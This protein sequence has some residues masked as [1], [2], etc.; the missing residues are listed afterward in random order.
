MASELITAFNAGEA[1]RNLESRKD[2]DFYKRLCSVAENVDILSEGGATTRAGT[3]YIATTKNNTVAYLRPF[4]YS[5]EYSYVMELG[6]TYARIYDNQTEAVVANLVTPWGINDVQ[7]LDFYRSYDVM[8][9]CHPDHPTQ[10]ITRT[11]VDAFSIAEIE[12]DYPPLLEPNVTAT[13]LTVGATTGTG[14]ALTASADLFD[15]SH[16]GAVFAI[17]HERTAAQ[18]SV[19]GSSSATFQSSALDVS[20][21]NW[22]ID[23]GGT[24][25]GLLM[26]ERSFDGGSTWEAGEKIAD[27]TNIANANFF[28]ESTTREGA[29]TLIRIN[30]TKS[31]TKTP[32]DY[33]LSVIDLYTYGLVE[34]TAVTDAQNAVCTVL[35]TVGATSATTRWS[36]GAFS[37]YRGYPRTVTR[38]EDRLIFS[39]TNSE[40]NMLWMSYTG[41]YY[42][43]FA[44]TLADE[45]IRR[46]PPANGFTQWMVS[47]GDLFIGTSS[48]LITVTGYNPNQPL[49]PDNFKFNIESSFGSAQRRPVLANNVVLYLQKNEQTI[50]EILYDD[51]SKS[52]RSQDISRIAKHI[53]GEGVSEID[54]VRL[55]EQRMHCILHSGEKG[56]LTYERAEEVVAW[57]RYATDGSY[58]STCVVDN[59]AEDAVWNIVLRDGSYYIEKEQSRDFNGTDYWCVDSGKYSFLEASTDISD[60]SK[61]VVPSTLGEGCT[62]SVFNSKIIW[63]DSGLTNEGETVWYDPTSTYAYW[64]DGSE[65]L[66]SAVGD[67]GGS[68]T[69]YFKLQDYPDT[70]TVTGAGDPTANGIYSYNIASSQWEFAYNSETTSV[71]SYDSYSLWFLHA[72]DLYLA[73]AVFGDP[74]PPKTEWGFLPP[75][76]GPA[77]TLE[78]TIPTTQYVG[79]GSWSGTIVKS[80]SAI[81]TVTSTAHGLTN[82]D[83][84]RIDSVVG[85]TELNEN[86]YTISDKTD[87]TFVLKSE[88]NTVV[89]DGGSF[90]DYV[91]DGTITQ[92]TN[93]FTGLTHLEGKTVAVI[94][95]GMYDGDHTVASGAITLNDYYN[96]IITGLKY[97]CTVSPMPIEPDLMDRSSSG[98]QKLI[99]GK[100]K[101]KLKDTIG[102]SFG[103]VLAKMEKLIPETYPPLGESWDLVN[104]DVEVYCFD[105]WDDIKRVYFKQTLPL[106]AEILS[107]VITIDVRG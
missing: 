38:H 7:E 62:P 87:D 34:V 22:R 20:F 19:N 100:V 96:R 91:S 79:Q 3:K 49:T 85:M 47:K 83:Y 35:S 101:L 25:N 66:I 32:L 18:S 56:V 69:N 78:Y 17:N 76:L 94:A 106:P 60:I 59:G 98:K 86:I 8:W 64:N 36:E 92:V 73:P 28:F 21:S 75:T 88:D 90:A 89:I 40:P 13:T 107:M 70:I 29:N 15:P 68:P 95:D 26:I 39:G 31:G 97:E 80:D 27:T 71:I 30:W 42:N 48:E 9:V 53:V 61:T 74:N 77:P 12:F 54:L 45:A 41:D 6:E 2:L 44:G 65:W 11:A 55:P 33:N 67:V 4:S 10:L 14:V 84:V 37:N 23:T 43:F 5:D 46:A 1:S 63:E 58:I 103:S 104:D 82:G 52:Y 57:R 105:G 99:N 81:L 24:W 51:N 102:G 93:T 50:R 72:V 16:V